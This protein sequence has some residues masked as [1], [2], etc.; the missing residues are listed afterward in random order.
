[1]DF[2]DPWGEGHK[3]WAINQPEAIQKIESEMAQQ[4]LYIADGHHRYD[5]ALTYRRERKA[6]DK[7]F[8][9]QR[10]LQLCFNVFD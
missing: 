3:V 6:T 2:I 8:H 5:S 9:G 1:M 7:Q 4:P 10:R